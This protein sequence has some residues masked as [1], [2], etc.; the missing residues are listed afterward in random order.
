MDVCEMCHDVE[1]DESCGQC[2]TNVENA[3]ALEPPPH[4]AGRF[5]HAAHIEHE[6]SCA[7]CHGDPLA[8]DQPDTEPYHPA[9][10]QCRTC[11]ETA[12][13]Y[14]DCSV[15]H[16]ASLE[17]TPAS[18]ARNWLHV[19]GIEAHLDQTTC[20]NCH[21]QSQCEEC[22]AG[23]NVMPRSHGLNYI[24]EHA[25]EARGNETACTTCHQEPEFCSSCHTAEHILPRS[26]SRIDWARSSDGGRHAVDAQFEIES[27]I[28][29]HDAGEDSPICAR[30][31]GG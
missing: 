19:H 20:E 22:H 8:A 2:H 3:M 18:H 28:A 5:S 29:C 6:M 9:K 10:A 27:C 21:T 26:H 25:I 23:D 1:D 7:A 4:A 31:H 11:H 14:A 24:F 16:L 30:C 17:L 12:G 13:G 15:C